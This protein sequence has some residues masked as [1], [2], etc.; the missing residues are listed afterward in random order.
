M[1]KIRH[2]F[3][4]AFCLFLLCFCYFV[5]FEKRMY[6]LQKK[7][8]HVM[9]ESYKRHNEMEKE[10]RLIKTDVQKVEEILYVGDYD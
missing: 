4:L 8:E 5:T 10:I 1:I 7:A 2:F 9:S 3:E 6:R